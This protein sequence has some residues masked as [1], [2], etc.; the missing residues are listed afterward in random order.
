VKFTHS[1]NPEQTSLLSDAMEPTVLRGETAN[2]T[3]AARLSGQ[4]AQVEAIMSDG[5]WHTLPNLAAEL[6]RRFGTRYAETS[7]SA[8]VRDL[9][10]RGWKVE[11]ERT[12][13]GSGLYQYRAIKIETEAAA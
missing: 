4:R 13:P 12:R 1:R 6:K 9:R 10:R 2:P 8:R 11:H 3:D 5:F 7:I